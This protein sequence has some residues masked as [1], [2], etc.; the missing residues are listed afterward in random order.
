MKEVS[1]EKGTKKGKI[2]LIIAICVLVLLVAVVLLKLYR[3]GHL[4]E[5]SQQYYYDHF[6]DNYFDDDKTTSNNTPK[7]KQIYEKVED[8]IGEVI[9]QDD[10]FLPVEAEEE[11][12]SDDEVEYRSSQMESQT[13]SSVSEDEIEQIY[14]DLFA[15][16]DDDTDFQ[17]K[18]DYQHWEISHLTHIRDAKGNEKAFGYEKPTLKQLIKVIDKK[19]KIPKKY[20]PL[21]KEYC[22]YWLTNYPDTDFSILYKNLQTLEIVECT[23]DEIVQATISPTAIACYRGAE[24]KIYIN[25]KGTF[26]DRASD[27]YIVLMHEFTHAARTIKLQEN[28]NTVTGGFYDKQILGLYTDE[29]LDTYFMSE[30][31]GLGYKQTHYT[32]ACSYM[33]IIM[34]C[35]GDNYT[36]EDYMNHSVNYFCQKM[37][38][39]MGDDMYAYHVIAQMEAEMS[40]HYTSYKAVNYDSY[41]DMFDYLVRMYCTKHLK[42]GMSSDEADEV[43]KNFMAEIQFNFEILQQPYPEVTQDKFEKQFKLC[44]KELGVK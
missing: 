39:Y 18:N 15:P 26:T 40:A 35:I 16:A 10:E 23:D 30:L 21:I 43:F 3:G 20:K 41:Q 11:E 33:R 24:N 5:K 31:Q 9:E 13:T 38:E 8:E 25:K 17:W 1:G 32:L 7:E 29:A 22:T 37:D 28:K 6:Y 4:G 27:D 36:F 19:S 34:E 14:L 2:I 12:A 42:A 44:C